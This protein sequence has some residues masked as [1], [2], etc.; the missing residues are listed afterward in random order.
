VAS[1]ST[2]AASTATATID[3]VAPVASAASASTT[4]VADGASAPVSQPA[5]PDDLAPLLA[6]AQ[7]VQAT[8]WRELALH[9]NV[10]IGEGEPCQAAAQ[11]RLACFR[12]ASGGLPVVRQLGRPG[13][14]TLR[15]G[16]KA[17]VY[18]VLLALN[19]GRA[20]LQAGARRF[21][22]GLPALA[23]VWRGDFATFW[24]MPP[25]WRTDAGSA[26]TSALRVWIDQR[27]QAAG[28]P[29]GPVLADRVR[30]FQLAQGLPPDGQA[31]PMTLMRLA[32]SG[33]DAEPSLAAPR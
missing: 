29:G 4:A 22:L 28:H 5:P 19:D 18:A 1:T 20:T 23:R 33:E 9:W 15:D 13:L 6:A 16:G 30:A 7:T 26:D 17:P 14:L 2:A 25:G 32:P 12:S 21:E 3:A 27:L 24:R 11:A 10:A 31:G 8:A